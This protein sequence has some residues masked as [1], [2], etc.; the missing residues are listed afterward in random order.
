MAAGLLCKF[1]LISVCLSRKNKRLSL[2][3]CSQIDLIDEMN[4]SG[5]MEFSVPAADADT[6]FPIQAR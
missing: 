3:V 5:S 2:G 1:T 4:R 6:F